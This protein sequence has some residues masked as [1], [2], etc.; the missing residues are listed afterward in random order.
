MVKRMGTRAR[1]VRADSRVKAARP[2]TKE[3]VAVV[4]RK[5]KATFAASSAARSGASFQAYAAATSARTV[6]TA[7]PRKAAARKGILRNASQPKAAI[8]HTEKVSKKS[9]RLQIL[10]PER[11]G[12]WWKIG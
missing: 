2:S 11:T 5:I 12:K 8:V 9:M 6:K 3:C 1:V 10:N 7:V 4:R